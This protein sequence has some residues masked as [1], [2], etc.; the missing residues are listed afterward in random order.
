M[1]ALFSENPLQAGAAAPKIDSGERTTLPLDV[2]TKDTMIRFDWKTL[3]A[4]AALV[5][6]AAGCQGKKNQVATNTSG[7]SNVASEQLEGET[8]PISDAEIATL[9]ANFL[10]VNFEFDQAVLVEDARAALSEN[11]EILLLHGDVAVQI[12]GHADHWGSDIYNL[13]LG[14]RR[15]D[16]VKGYLLDLGVPASQLSVIS[17]GEERPLVDDMDRQKESPNRRAEFVVTA[18]SDKAASSY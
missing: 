10:R 12:E 1:L 15:G 3:I 5:T 13:A 8:A 16:T 9:R 7:T 4:A 17:Y 11:A 14:Q 18:G 2:W 6:L